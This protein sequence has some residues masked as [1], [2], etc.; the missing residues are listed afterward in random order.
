MTCKKK[1]S[2]LIFRHSKAYQMK[3]WAK[4]NFSKFLKFF[5]IFKIQFGHLRVEM[6]VRHVPHF[7]ANCPRV[8]HAKKNQKCIHGFMVKL[9]KMCFGH[10]QLLR[11]LRAP[12][13]HFEGQVFS[14]STQ[15]FFWWVYHYICS[16]GS[17]FFSHFN[18]CST[19]S[20]FWPQLSKTYTD[21]SR[22][23][24]IISNL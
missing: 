4:K 14:G 13:R 8:H 7:L 16:M 6:Q 3:I 1:L 21:G 11:D 20:D 10:D 19:S 18:F 24:K 9:V 23:L 22:R 17:V 2:Q 12:D 15:A 5:W